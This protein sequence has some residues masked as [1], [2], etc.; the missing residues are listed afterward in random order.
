[1]QSLWSQVSDLAASAEKLHT[2]RVVMM[3]NQME[4]EVAALLQHQCVVVG[5]VDIS[6]SDVSL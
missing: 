4:M 1:M 3:K 6:S 2:D 5:I